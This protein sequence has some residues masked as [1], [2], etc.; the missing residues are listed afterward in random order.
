MYASDLQTI[1]KQEQIWLTVMFGERYLSRYCLQVSALCKGFRQLL[2]LS[3]AQFIVNL[4]IAL[5]L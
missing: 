5:I 2:Q 1:A 3:Y 4:R